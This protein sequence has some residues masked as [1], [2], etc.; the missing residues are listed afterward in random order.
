MNFNYEFIKELSDNMGKLFG[1]K[2]EIVIHDFSNGYEHT[3]VHIVNGNLSGREVGGSPTNLFFEHLN[4]LEEKKEE[5]SSYFNRTPDGRLI[6]SS[7]TFLKGENGEISGSICI[8]IDVTDLNAA[9]FHV[10]AFLSEKNAP[11][12][13]MS[14]EH[15]AKDVNELVEVCLEQVQSD[16]GKPARKMNKQEKIAALSYLKDKGVLQIAKAN[17]RLCDF[18]GISKF[19]LYNYLGEINEKNGSGIEAEP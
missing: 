14:N 8:N 12:K 5:F 3:I 13:T 4:E 17:V 19:T 9:L 10:K 16:I 15:F 6:K 2:C 18:F 11:D 7:T 1:D